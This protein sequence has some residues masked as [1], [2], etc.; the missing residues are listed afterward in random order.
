MAEIDGVIGYVKGQ[1]PNM[2]AFKQQRTAASFAGVTLETIRQ[3]SGT[4][5]VSGTVKLDLPEI[6]A[7]NPAATLL[8]NAQEA[9]RQHDITR[10]LLLTNQAINHN[11]G[12]QAYLLRS[13]LNTQDGNLESGEA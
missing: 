1:T 9:Y 8:L 4:G 11:G 3:A 5:V 10:A 6:V 7:A 2:Q 13:L 12:A